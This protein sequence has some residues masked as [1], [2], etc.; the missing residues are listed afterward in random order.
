MTP[1]STNPTTTKATPHN[2]NSRKHDGFNLYRDI[3]RYAILCIAFLICVFNPYMLY[4]TDVTQFDSSQCFATLGA[5][6]GAFLCA[7]FIAIYLISF[8]PKRFAKILAFI[9]SLTLIVGLIYNFILMDNYGAMDHFILQAP[10]TKHQGQTLEFILILFISVIF[11]TLA[12][13]KMLYVLK[14][15]LITLFIISAINVAFIILKRIETH[16]LTA[17]ISPP[18]YATE[19]FT[20]SKNQKNI[21]VIVLDMFS[22]SHTPYLL[23][24][25]P[26]FRE[27]LDGFVLFDNALSTTNSTIH[28]VA[29]LIGGEYYAT[30]NMNK[31]KANLKQEIQNAFIETSNAFVENDFSVAL[32]AYTESNIKNLAA[33]NVFALDSRSEVFVDYYGSELGILERIYRAKSYNN[34]YIVGQ[35]I[36]FG[37]FKFVPE[38]FASGI[39]NDGKWLFG[40]EW[41]LEKILSS[42]QS[43][44]DFYAISHNASVDSN[45]PTFKFFHSMMT[46]L[47]YGAYFKDGK[48]EF[49]GKESAWN[50]YPH[51]AKMNYQTFNAML[52]YYQHYDLEACA[53][54]YLADYV[55]LLKT[56]GIYDNTQIFVIS[57]HGGNDG[58]NMPMT[59]ESD[60]RPDALFLFKD[61]NAKGAVRVD[62]RIMA[63]YDIASI[64]CENLPNGCPNVAPNILK[65]YPQNREIIHTI[66][67]SW[68]LEHHKANKWILRRIFK[69]RGNIHN[70]NN[71]IEIR[72]AE[73][74]EGF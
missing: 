1:I 67:D 12:L 3:S 68:V 58:I 73:S 33:P 9:L 43:S 34:R 28:S 4:G 51:K 47:P 35:L 65:N 31:R 46:H 22:G 38:M 15:V 62:S 2:A 70:A 63:N 45:K 61:F 20:Y 42:I 18:P 48:C 36:S 37:I 6:F 29:T 74:A 72:D 10:P 56:L 19:L 55:K 24:Q 23:E 21:V 59:S 49:G 53:L 39:Y 16:T 30:Y 66:P 50:D 5:L 60:F 44:A 52:N 57:D 32:I 71:W 11:T 25:F 17:Q 69:V 26:Q 7:S 27:A 64:F 14:V 41:Y 54:Q 8:I 40:T 13:K